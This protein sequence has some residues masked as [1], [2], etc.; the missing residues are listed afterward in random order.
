[1][2]F[3]LETYIRFQKLP[4]I[5]PNI[6]FFSIVALNITFLTLP[7]FTFSPPLCLSLFFYNLKFPD[8]H[9]REVGVEKGKGGEYEIG[10]GRWRNRRWAGGKR[11][12]G[13]KVKNYGVLLDHKKRWGRWMAGIAWEGV[14]PD[15]NKSV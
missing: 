4:I 9:K 14:L 7:Y 1:M 13:G 3:Y 15:L 11:V 6:T 10:R 2:L 8:F 5:A 12:W